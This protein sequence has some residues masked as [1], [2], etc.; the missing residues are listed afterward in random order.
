MLKHRWVA[1]QLSLP[2]SPS[3]LLMSQMLP[4]EIYKLLLLAHAGST[5]HH[6]CENDIP[7]LVSIIWTFRITT[8]CD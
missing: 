5:V 7:M 3:P 8:M 6:F 1:E 2:P 4:I